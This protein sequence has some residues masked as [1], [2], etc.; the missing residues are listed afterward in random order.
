[1]KL[2]QQR[3]EQKKYTL[4]VPCPRF[5]HQES[6]DVFKQGFQDLWKKY[7]GNESQT[8]HV[9]IKWIERTTTPLA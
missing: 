8:K 3:E 5:I 6:R 2:K 9:Q 7:F 1:M 4:F